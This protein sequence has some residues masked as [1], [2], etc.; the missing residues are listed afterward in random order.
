MCVWH[1]S[2]DATK[3]DGSLG[4]LVNHSRL[5]PNAEVKI[6]SSD[7]RP[8]LCLFAADE[9]ASGQELLY[10]YGERSKATIQNFAWL[11]Q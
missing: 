10:D 9:I 4:R 7:T 11:K 6:V 1:N 3:E 5:R 8:F 2:I